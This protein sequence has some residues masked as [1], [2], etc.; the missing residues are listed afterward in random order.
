MTQ[1]IQLVEYGDPAICKLSNRDYKELSE[2]YAETLNIIPLDAEKYWLKAKQHVGRL[3]LPDTLI[4]IEPKVGEL[5]FEFIFSVANGIQ[6]FRQE[7]TDYTRLKEKSIF[8][9]IISFLLDGVQ[10]LCRKGITRIYYQFDSNLPA[11]RGRVLIKEDLLH[12]YALHSRIFCRYDEFGPDNVHNQIIKYTLHVLLRTPL[13][14]VELHRKIRHLLT[15]FEEVSFVPISS[16]SFPKVSY[17][18]LTNQYRPLIA[19]CKLLLENSSLQLSKRGDLF[20]MSYLVNMDDLFDKFLASILIQRLA[21]RGSHVIGAGSKDEFPVDVENEKS[22]TPDIVIKEKDKVLLVIDAKYEENIDN[23][24]LYQMWTYCTAL[25]VKQGVL[26]HPK[27]GI[28]D[29][30]IHTLLNTNVKTRLTSI[31]INKTT[32]KELNDECDAFLTWID[33]LLP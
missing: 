24:D 11:I 29:D 18:R 5:V 12:N 3:V 33:G 31:D 8:E 16:K 13:Q 21:K 28:R 6:P 10:S 17:S 14:N 9:R 27:R 25:N 23:N 26:V 1:A 22:I 19:F 30:E 32:I 4:T 7:V 20:F 2:H 15:F